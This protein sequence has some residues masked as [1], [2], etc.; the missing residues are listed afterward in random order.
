MRVKIED[1]VPYGIQGAWGG[2]RGVDSNSI[3]YAGEFEG[4]VIHKRILA[5]HDRYDI[6]F[7]EGGMHIK[8]TLGQIRAKSAA[9]KKYRAHLNE[10][11]PEYIRKKAKEKWEKE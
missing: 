10:Y 5:A 4:G 9:R 7:D 6:T 1:N 11:D 2:S 8:A 3:Y